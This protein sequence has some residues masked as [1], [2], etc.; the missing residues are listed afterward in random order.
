MAAFLRDHP[1]WS[2]YWDKRHAVWRIAEDLR[3]LKSQ[4]NGHS[5]RVRF[6]INKLRRFARPATAGDRVYLSEHADV[7]VGIRSIP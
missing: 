4:H 3:R 2:A 6:Y 1:W 5:V 7:P